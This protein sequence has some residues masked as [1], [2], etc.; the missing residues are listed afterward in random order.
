MLSFATSARVRTTV[1]DSA[2]R[3]LPHITKAAYHG[4]SP[5]TSS[6]RLTGGKWSSKLISYLRKG[7]AATI[8]SAASKPSAAARPFLKTAAGRLA[9]KS[10]RTMLHRITARLGANTHVKTLLSR[11][12]QKLHLVP[13]ASRLAARAA[14]PRS[15]VFASGGRWHPYLNIFSQSLRSLSGPKNISSARVVM[16]QLQ[17]Q[18]LVIG[19][20]SHQRRDLASA[21]PLSHG[22]KIAIQNT[23]SRRTPAASGF[24]ANTS[25]KPDAVASNP[26]ATST[27]TAQD[28]L[29]ASQHLHQVAK[30][31]QDAAAVPIE[32]CVTITVPYTI[33]SATQNQPG[34]LS[35]VA[36]HISDVQRIQQRHTLLL[37]RLTERLAASGWSIQYRHVSIPTD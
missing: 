17:R 31:A 26:A 30:A 23:R 32:Q 4:A 5:H 20:L 25:T 15:W 36:Q 7:F 14:N 24:A 19:S 3:R 34:V 21:S 33:T 8:G 16:A 29:Q 12:S 11:F 27:Q 22:T 6:S 10:S 35:D 37:S 1:A 18:A 9:A 13:G 28:H 2:K